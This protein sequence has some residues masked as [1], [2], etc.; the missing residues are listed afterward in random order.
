MMNLSGKRPLIKRSIRPPNYETPVDAFNSLYT[1]NDRFF[2]RWHLSV[3]PEIDANSW[4]L[5]VGGPSVQKPLALTLDALRKLPVAEVVAVNM[6]A[7]NRRGLFMPH[8][9]GVEWGNGAMGNARWRGARLKDVLSRAGVGRDALE[10]A[11]RGQDHGP[12]AQTPQFAKS[13]PMWKAMDDN[14]ILAYEMN[15][16]PLPMLNGFPVRLIVPGWAG[17]YWMKQISEIDVLPTPFDSFWMKT[18]YRI[19]LGKF[20]HLVHFKSQETPEATSTPITEMVV[21]SLITQ[22]ADGHR[23]QLGQQTTVRGVAWDGG[24][25]IAKVEVS[26][27]GGQ[28]WQA[29]RL[30]R[31]LGNYAWRQ[32]QATFQPKARGEIGLLARATSKSGETQSMDLIWNPAGYHNNVPQQVNVTVA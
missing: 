30:G 25:G 4:R 27:D 11:F 20:P 18:A 12:I 24:H 7:G 21:N 1:P 6:C 5:K 22:P 3:I 32:W 15:G 8:V 26:V 29:A 28:S 19:P 2:V 9:A 31:D 13:L 23:L 17:T 14:T 16:A 10:V